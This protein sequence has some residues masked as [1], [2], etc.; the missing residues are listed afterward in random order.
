MHVHRIK[1][2]RHFLRNERKTVI[3][4]LDKFFETKSYIRNAK[5][6][7][8]V[9][10]EMRLFNEHMQKVEDDFRIKSGLSAIESGKIFFNV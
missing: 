3:Q 7:E 5:P 10:E 9:P 6:V 2:N 8:I 1:P 4:N